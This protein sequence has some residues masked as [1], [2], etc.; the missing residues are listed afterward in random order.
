MSLTINSSCVGIVL[1]WGCQ[2]PLLD[3]AG[4]KRRKVL[5]KCPG[6]F[7]SSMAPSQG[8][9]APGDVG[10]GKKNIPKIRKPKKKKIQS[11]NSDTS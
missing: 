9:A 5:M 4:G 6:L 10:Y 1:P 11:E 2:L 7:S 3:L 8:L